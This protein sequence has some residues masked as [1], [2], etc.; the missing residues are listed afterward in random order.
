[1]YY[2]F[3]F[4]S[5]ISNNKYGLISF[6]K[7]G[8]TTHTIEGQL[9][10]DATKFT[11]GAE[12]LVYSDDSADSLQALV[13]AVNF[14]FRTAV[15]KTIVLVQCDMCSGSDIAKYSHLKHL[16]LTRDI[17]LHIL[18]DQGFRLSGNRSPKDKILGKIL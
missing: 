8:P 6:G 5:A 13:S 17:T 16:L 7:R 1:M 15:S 10:N 18:R 14:P 9:L 4:S 12:S 2:V 11:K 3:L